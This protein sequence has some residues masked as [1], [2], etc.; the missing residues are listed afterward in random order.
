MGV[1][2][3]AGGG[4]SGKKIIIE[5]DYGW[6][7]GDEIGDPRSLF[8]IKEKL[9]EGAF[10]SVF[11][12]V[13]KQSNFVVAV[14]EI[15]IGKLKEQGTIQKE[16]ELLRQCRH[17]N[18]VQY[19]DDSIWI[20]TDFCGAGSIT[21]CIELTDST[22]TETQI[23]IVIAAAVDGLAFLHG[24]GI[25]HRD[26]KC[27]NILLT[28]EGVVKIAD[29]GVSEK[30]TQTIGVRNS[31]VGTPYWMSPEVIT[32]SDYG[33]EADIWSLGIT[34]IEMTDGVPPH[35]TVHP[36]RA[37]FKIPFLPPPTLMNPSAYSPV[38][39]DF[40]ASCLTKEPRKRPTAV[41]LQKHPFIRDL[42][43]RTDRDSRKP[44]IEKVQEVLTLKEARRLEEEMMGDRSDDEVGFGGRREV[45]D[46]TIVSSRGV[47][48]ETRASS[49][50]NLRHVQPVKQLKASPVALRGKARSSS[51]S[52]N[53]SVIIH[54]DEEE[55]DIGGD[56]VKKAGEEF[57]GT[58]VLSEGKDELGYYGDAAANGTVVLHRDEEDVEVVLR[59]SSVPKNAFDTG[60]T[61][62]REG[63]VQEDVRLERNVP[64]PSFESGTTV[65]HDGVFQEDV[66]LERNVP[67]PSF[68]TDTTVI[69]EAE[70]QVNIAVGGR[71]FGVAEKKPSPSRNPGAEYQL[72]FSRLM[73]EEIDPEA[74]I[75]AGPSSRNQDPLYASD[76]EQ[77][78]R[79]SY[80]KRESMHHEAAILGA[81]QAAF[82]SSQQ[83]MPRKTF[84]GTAGGLRRRLPTQ[85]STALPTSFDPDRPRGVSLDGVPSYPSVAAARTAARAA[86]KKYFEGQ[87]QQL[88]Q[89][90]QQ[91]QVVQEKAP[92][93]RMAD[94][95]R[96][97]LEKFRS[98]LKGVMSDTRS[99]PSHHMREDGVNSDRHLLGISTSR[100]SARMISPISPKGKSPSFGDVT[101]SNLNPEETLRRESAPAP[102]VGSPSLS[103]KTRTSSL[104]QNSYP[105]TPLA[106]SVKPIAV[107][108]MDIARGLE[109]ER[110]PPL[111]PIVP[112]ARNSPTLPKRRNSLNSYAPSIPLPMKRAD[113]D[114]ESDDVLK[115]L[116]GWMFGNQPPPGYLRRGPE[117]SPSSDIGSPDFSETR[118]G[119]DF[120]G[121]ES[122]PKD[123]D[124]ST[125]HE[126]DLR[127]KPSNH[128]RRNS[129]GGAS[130]GDRMASLRR[131]PILLRR[132][133]SSIASW[134]VD[135]SKWMSDGEDA[136]VDGDVVEIGVGVK[137]GVGVGRYRE[138]EEVREFLQIPGWVPLVI[139][140]TI[141]RLVRVLVVEFRHNF[142]M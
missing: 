21:D 75:L 66:R 15:L 44:L 71:A 119:E 43:G 37:M 74:L 14:K 51:A 125:I 53:G 92:K 126:R 34:A 138:A 120:F 76:D 108:L 33:T 47:T 101:K 112:E 118:L 13:H 115:S 87:R 78:R 39:N 29:F 11:K 93:A 55:I 25:V 113:N 24:R 49:E 142:W 60:T 111:T 110:P 100:H 7:G 27:A 35:S 123:D 103:I 3:G 137:I 12:A 67:R 72:D 134:K 86:N 79:Q 95:L 106:Y 23:R 16:I 81:A 131:K 117:T 94:R 89:Q 121:A 84:S 139:I 128:L 58:V 97:R 88:L 46:R 140:D 61:V 19:Y 65:I 22:F 135:K 80:F 69:H 38:F 68:E 105:L 31:V 17:I 124:S 102:L 98:T 10:G 82:L 83:S 28:E 26:V 116:A 136:D 54:S 2:G 36:M 32:G 109:N 85:G 73:E 52:S 18:T 91:Q 62:I 122:P 4:L 56:A 104:N 45:D 57:F 141:V 132:S 6:F 1:L 9:G 96:N 99:S 77:S 129:D 63:V 30:L 20:L 40:I 59:G 42:V 8:T 70:K 64:R 127:K 114:N 50:G 107:Q 130:V 133:T 41:E 48:R 5:P 90:Q